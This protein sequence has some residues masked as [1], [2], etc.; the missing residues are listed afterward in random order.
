MS[1]LVFQSVFNAALQDYEVQAGIKL[2]GH[3]LSRELE[4]CNSVRYIEWKW[5]ALALWFTGPPSA[6]TL[7]HCIW[8]KW[9]QG[10]QGIR[11]SALSLI[12]AANVTNTKGNKIIFSF[13]NLQPITVMSHHSIVI[14]YLARRCQLRA[15]PEDRNRGGLVKQPGNTHICGVVRQVPS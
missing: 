9:G 1:N 4:M 7:Y 10:G 8:N 12:A 5:L 13:H 2:V 3:L 14:W 11:L 6:R 15:H